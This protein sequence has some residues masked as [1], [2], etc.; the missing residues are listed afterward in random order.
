MMGSSDGR[1]QE[2]STPTGLG[3]VNIDR[4]ATQRKMKSTRHAYLLLKWMSEV[5]SRLAWAME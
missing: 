2:Y 1:L 5:D 3:A 4:D